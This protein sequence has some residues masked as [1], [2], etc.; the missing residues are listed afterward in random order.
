MHPPDQLC[1]DENLAAEVLRS[2]IRFGNVYGSE[3]SMNQSDRTTIKGTNEV[4]TAYTS[5]S[6]T[7]TAQD[8]HYLYNSEK[9]IFVSYEDPESLNLKCKCAGL[10]KISA[11]KTE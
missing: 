7:S 1:A 10:K 2:L 4:Y 3:K 9:K 6:I 11:H 5:Q 8:H